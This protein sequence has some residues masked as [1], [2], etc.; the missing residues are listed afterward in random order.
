MDVGTYGYLVDENNAVVATAQA[1]QADPSGDKGKAE[2]A[3]SF[4]FH[5]VP[6]SA[7]YGFN[8]DGAGTGTIWVY[9]E[10]VV[11]DDGIIVSYS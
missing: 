3:Y 1:V 10:D 7:R 8:N 4:T 6:A 2:A 9:N 11:R 5:N